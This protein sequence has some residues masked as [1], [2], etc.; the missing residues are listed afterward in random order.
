VSNIS[1]CSISEETKSPR[2]VTYSGEDD[3]L[4]SST[5]QGLGRLVGS[6]LELSVVGARLQ[7]I[8]D[9]LYSC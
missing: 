4:S 2:G 1:F 5:V 8:Q 7:Q 9:F 6:F 3:N